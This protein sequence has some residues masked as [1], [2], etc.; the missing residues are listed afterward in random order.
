VSHLASSAFSTKDRNGVEI[1]LRDVVIC[2]GQEG[3]V[4]SF[5]EPL[6]GTIAHNRRIA[7]VGVRVIGSGV[8]VI[9]SVAVWP[10]NLCT[11]GRLLITSAEIQTLNAARD[12]LAAIDKRLPHDWQGGRCGAVCDVGSTSIFDVLC[13]LHSYL[14]APISGDQLHNRKAGE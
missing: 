14:D 9:G 5:D 11:V 13:S 7:L 2:N 3:K 8:R 4:L 12:I 1:K 10:A 6:G